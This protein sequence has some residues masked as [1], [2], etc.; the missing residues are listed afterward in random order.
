MVFDIWWVA[1][2]PL[3]PNSSINNIIINVINTNINITI[4]L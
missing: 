2:P 3:E 1:T 4:N